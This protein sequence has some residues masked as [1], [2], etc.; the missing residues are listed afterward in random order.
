M[1]NLIRGTHSRRTRR[2]QKVLTDASRAQA[3][4]RLEEKALLAEVPRLSSLPDAPVTLFLDVDGNVET[5][6]G[7]TRF[8]NGND[9]I[10]P[11]Y[12]SD[13]DRANLTDTEAQEITDI[14]AV[15]AEDFAPF[16]VNVTTIDPGTYN[17]FQTI[18]VAVGGTGFVAGA[19]GIAFLNAF[20]NSASNTAFAFTEVNRGVAL[21]SMTISHEAG[22]TFGLRHHSQFDANGNKVSE[23]DPGDSETGPIMGAPF[24]ARRALWGDGPAD[25]TVTDLQDDMEYMSRAGNRTFKYRDDLQGN[26]IDT[27]FSPP[28]DSNGVMQVDG[29]LERHDDSDFF[30]IETDSG[31]ISF[32]VSVLDVGIARHPGNNL[33]TVLRLYDASGEVVAEDMP[34]D[35]FDASITYQAAEGTYY[36]EVTSDGIYGSAGQYTFDGDVIPL[37]A[38]PEMISPVGIIE[39]A[40]PLFS[41]TQ[42]S[43]VATYTLQVNSLATGQEVINVGGI[44]ATNYTPTDSLG[45][46]KYQA[47]VQGVTALG[48]RSE[49]S[50]FLGF[51]VDVA[52]P[53]VPRLVTPRGRIEDPF[54]PFVWEAATDAAS[55]E[56]QVTSVATG[57]VTIFRTGI[58][59]L[60]YTHFRPHADG[61]YNWT[62]RAV[63]EVG[64]RGVWATPRKFTMANAQAGVPEITN[65][66]DGTKTSA[67]RPWITWTPTVAAVSYELR[68]DNLSTGENNVIRRSDIKQAQYRPPKKLPQGVYAFSVRAFDAVGRPTDWSPVER[69]TID[70]PRPTKPTLTGPTDLIDTQFATFTWTRAG[71]AKRYELVVV[72]E[73]RDDTVVLR[74]TIRGGA[75]LSY[76][77]N[78]KLP[79]STRLVALLRAVNEVGEVSEWSQLSFGIDV[80]VPGRPKVTGPRRNTNGTTDDRTPTFSWTLT[81]AAVSYDLKVIDLETRRTIIR[82]KSVKTDSFTTETRLD[83]KRYRVVVRARNSAGEFSRWSRAYD[84]VIDEA[85]PDTPTMNGPRGTVTARR[86]RFRWE[87]VKAA[88]F[89]L[90]IKDLSTNSTRKIS[91]RD[92]DVSDDGTEASFRIEDRLGKSTYETWVQAVNSGNEKSAYSNSVGFTIVSYEGYVDPSDFEVPETPAVPEA[93]AEP[94]EAPKAAETQFIVDVQPEVTEEAAA[95]ARELVAAPVVNSLEAVAEEVDSTVR[96]AAIASVM[97]SDWWSP[98]PTVTSD[99][100]V[101]LEEGNSTVAVGTSLALGVVAVP[102]LAGRL[103]DRLR[104]RKKRAGE[105]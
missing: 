82:Q 66:D 97:G 30:E 17:N 40:T 43:G 23:Y 58:K 46:G 77:S 44:S 81:D 90:F 79:Q 35:S 64:E 15:V 70:I 59:G 24:G 53:G 16:D 85:Q 28:F 49:W 91:V 13:G 94:A 18:T 42:A 73:N 39:D 67:R 89:I 96:D 69:A 68:V 56:L 33:N 63:N 54:T 48:Q 103:F 104:D 34:T 71:R 61:E 57:D 47:R 50:D 75:T 101:G 105:K 11:P 6:P 2:L 88:R 62:V 12:D 92:W 3:I 65:P 1:L 29:I 22:H 8:N 60:T 26:S 95:V 83:E 51:E 41:W 21:A 31:E 45:E 72:D 38:R 78:R 102:T 93:A 74:R 84:F 4:E 7:W 55:Y 80:P 99:T 14:W 87:N 76:T 86:P 27:A 5:D 32:S 10:T 37:P 9:I 52:P 98:E 20:S 19:G 100:D 25:T 36:V